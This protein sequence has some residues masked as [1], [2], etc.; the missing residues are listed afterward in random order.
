MTANSGRETEKHHNK[1]KTNDPL[2]KSP[3]LCTPIRKDWPHI[4]PNDDLIGNEITGLTRNVASLA[5]S[6]PTSTSFCSTTDP[7]HIVEELHVRSYKPH[8]KNQLA[9]RENALKV[10]EQIPLR[11]SKG[12]KGIDSEF[13]SLKSMSRKNLNHEPHR[14]FGNISNAN[15]V[16]SIMQRTSST[17]S[18]P[19]LV[20]EQ[21]MKGKGIICNDFNMSGAECFNDGLILREW[22]K[23]EGYK[24]KKSERLYI[25]KQILELVDFAHSQGFVLQDMKPSCFALLTSNK[26]KYIG[27]YQ[28]VLDDRKSCFTL[29]KSCF[30]A[31]M[32]CNV[33]K[34]MPWEQDTCA[35][36][37]LST[38]K[39]KLC[40]ETTSLKQQH[41]FNCIHG[42]RTTTLNQTD[43]D[44]NMHME[45]KHA[46]TEEK[47]FIC[48]TIELEEKWYSSPEVLSDGTCTF[49]SN[50]YSLGVILF[51]VSKYFTLFLLS[52]TFVLYI[53]LKFH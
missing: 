39:Q 6:G 31:I 42:C 14:V 13:L 38:K 30:M 16:T 51:E 19:P 52:L 36:Q 9:I 5:G 26:I 28:Q 48:E 33:T 29:F 44:T 11:L 7:K 1:R 40:E 8:R 46:F 41:H 24:M 15:V 25:F 43:S 21:T 17:S 49:S 27:S 45:S 3:R 22:M 2:L 18:Y 53:L 12:Q 35:C 32:T 50:V 4:L 34:K 47:Q 20:V 37:S 10:E 23:F